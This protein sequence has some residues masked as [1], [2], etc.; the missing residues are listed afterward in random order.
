M[1]LGEVYRHREDWKFWAVGQGYANGL[2]GI[3]TDYGVA[4]G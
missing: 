2:A 1:I 4:I 3:A